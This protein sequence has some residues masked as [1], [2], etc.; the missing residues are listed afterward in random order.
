MYNKLKDEKGI[1]GFDITLSIFVI[2]VFSSLIA[3]LFYNIAIVNSSKKRKAMATIYATEILEEIGIMDY[4]EIT[5]E[6]LITYFSEKYT[7]NTNINIQD[8]NGNYEVNGYTITM[9]V[10]K[11]NETDGN[12]QKEDI[13]KTITVKVEYKIGKNVDSIEISRLKTKEI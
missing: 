5:N 13:I 12:E 4:D 9:K 10:S 2:I 6:N 1:T 7:N 11:Y 3:T 8:S